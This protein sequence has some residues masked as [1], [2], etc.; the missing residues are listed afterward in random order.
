MKSIAKINVLILGSSGLIG[1][2][3][4]NYLLNFDDFN[5]LGISRKRKFQKWD[6]NLD[7]EN[8]ND[9]ETLIFDFKPKIIINCAGKLI[10]DSNKLPSESIYLNAY[11]PHILVKIADN[12]G[13]KLFHISTDCVF[14]GNKGSYTEY[15]IKDGVSVYAKT[16]ALGEISSNNHL[17][18]RTSVIGPE[19]DLFGE[20]LFNWFMIQNHQ[21]EGYSG[22]IWSGVTTLVLARLVKRSI[23]LN[24]SGIYNITTQSPITKFDLLSI[25][26]KYRTKELIISSVVG[27]KSDKS[28]IDTR[29]EL[30]YTYPTYHTQVSEL[31]NLIHNESNGIYNHYKQLSQNIIHE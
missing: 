23:D 2:Q 26:N 30:N 5:I 16:K 27:V 11:F 21:I 22:S 31:F 14:S 12:I 13:A 3:V 18:L 10:S 28:L 24:L 29:S 6:L 25:I 15:D 17:T 19:L 9:L 7:L 8:I 1:H 20:E 4:Y